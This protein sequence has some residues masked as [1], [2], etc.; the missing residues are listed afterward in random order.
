MSPARILCLTACLSLA[1]GVPAKAQ[2]T[3]AASGGSTDAWS[4]HARVSVNLLSQTPAIS[5]TSTTSKPLYLETETVNASYQ[6]PSGLAY[7]GG[8]LVKVA[9]GFGVGVA[10]SFFKSHGDATV[11]ASVPHPFFFNKP[12]SASGTA[13]ALERTETAT[14][15]QAA[16]VIRTG[17]V[18]V[19]IAGGPTI[20]NVKQGLVSDVTFTDTYPYDIVTFT[21]ATTQTVTATK[22]GFHV[23]AD[24]GVRFSRNVGVGGLVRY[25]RATVDFSLTNAASGVTSDA[26]GVQAGGGIRFFF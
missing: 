11:A 14:H 5:F 4:D 20:F 12:R 18:D 17:R 13:P 21:G 2:T 15:I 1:D 7:D 22:I 26:G 16:Y 23:G 6:V 10:F 25:S 24:V 9:G 8:V 3:G 19:A